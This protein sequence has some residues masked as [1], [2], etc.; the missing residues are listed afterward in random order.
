MKR[1]LP[2]QKSEIR[3]KTCRKNTSSFP[4][5]FTSECIQN[6]Y[7]SMYESGTVVVSKECGKW[8]MNEEEVDI[9]RKTCQN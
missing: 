6:V 5:N 8:D 9:N 3:F 1:F 4:S 7:K 2:A